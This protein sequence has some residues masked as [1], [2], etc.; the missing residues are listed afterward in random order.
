MKT[1]GIIAEYNPFHNG[2]LYQIEKAKEL[3]GADTVVVVMSG[4][5]AQRGTPALLS[6]HLRTEMALR[7]GASLV[8][9]LPVCYATGSAELFALGA[10]SL[11]DKLGIVDSIC[12]GSESGNLQDLSKIADILSEEPEAYKRALQANL[13]SGISFP[14]ARVNALSE[15]LEPEDSSFLLDSPN[16]ILGIEYLKALRTLHSQMVPYTILRKESDYHEVE[17]NTSYSSAS[18]I[19]RQID[20]L[21]ALKGQLPSH[22]LTILKEN[23]NVCYPILQN[24]F[25]L[26]LKYRILKKSPGS[27]IKYQDVSKELANRIK[28]METDFLSFDQFCELLK[29]KEIT[30]TRINRALLHILLGMRKSSLEAFQKD[31]YHYYA[32]L[33]GFR[34]DRES[35]LTIVKKQG[36]L[37]ILTKLSATAYLPAVAQK[38]LDQDIIASNLYESAV[39]ERFKT[40][41]V[42]EYTKQIVRV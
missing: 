1:V 41:Y 7:A 32:R 31:G 42:N 4:D 19:R 36:T 24:D 2:H 8:F 38:M 21:D 18:A 16:N 13:K 9:E 22:C 14:S 15:Y 11:L 3:T 26:L 10:V 25:S 29:T 35:C 28:N 6:K 30:Y 5:F 23:Y 40:S 20:R 39:T 12:F 17:L 27:L 37:P 34:K 33:L